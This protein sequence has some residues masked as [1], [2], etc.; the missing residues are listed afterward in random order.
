ME[1]SSDE[2]LALLCNDISELVRDR[3]AWSLI[4]LEGEARLLDPTLTELVPDK[5]PQSNLKKEMKKWMNDGLQSMTY[6]N[7]SMRAKRYARP[8]SRTSLD[9]QAKQD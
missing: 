8:P 2:G 1:R 9:V 4:E 7:I 6:A 3:S 5:S